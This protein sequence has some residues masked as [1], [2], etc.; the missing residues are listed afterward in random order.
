MKRNASFV[1]DGFTFGILPGLRS[2]ILFRKKA[3]TLGE[4]RSCYHVAMVRCSRRNR[5]S[6]LPSCIDGRRGGL[7]N[8]GD[9]LTQPGSLDATG[10]RTSIEHRNCH[11]LKSSSG[12]SQYTLTKTQFPLLS[13][14]MYVEKKFLVTAAPCGV[15]PFKICSEIVMTNR[16]WETQERAYKFVKLAPVFCS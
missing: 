10:E 8:L 14:L 12:T 5:S 3:C 15:H 4:Q 6:V 1:V 13:A 7:G 2:S 9:Q 16:C 11:P